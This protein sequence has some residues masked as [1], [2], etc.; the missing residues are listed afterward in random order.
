MSTK[1]AL[2]KSLHLLVNDQNGNGAVESV[3]VPYRKTRKLW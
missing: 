1:I 2:S 3:V